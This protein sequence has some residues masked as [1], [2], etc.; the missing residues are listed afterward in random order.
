VSLIVSF[1]TKQGI[2]IASDSRGIIAGGQLEQQDA[3][4]YSDRNQKIYRIN[5]QCAVGITGSTGLAS[6]MIKKVLPDLREADSDVE[7][8]SD[9]L[10]LSCRRVYKQWFQP[11]EDQT[12]Q[13]ELRPQ[14]PI[15]LVLAGYSKDGEPELYAHGSTMGFVPQNYSYSVMAGIPHVATYLRTRLYDPDYDLDKAIQFSIYLIHETSIVK[16]QVGGPIKAVTIAR[17]SG[18]T[19]LASEDVDEYVQKIETAVG[20]FRGFFSP[21]KPGA[22]AADSG[23]S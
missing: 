21:E 19:S 12:D 20:D 1:K 11:D 4:V 23:N 2:V 6:S 14:V 17:E 13:A 8:V 9:Q 10:H 16:K 7:A 5:N 18:Y 3:P 22:S 15:M